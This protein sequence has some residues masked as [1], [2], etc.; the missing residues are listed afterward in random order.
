MFVVEA[1]DL[2]QIGG[3]DRETHD[4]VLVELRWVDVRR[5]LREAVW[6][7]PDVEAFDISRDVFVRPLAEQLDVRAALQRR[8]VGLHRTDE[9][10]RRFGQPRCDAGKKILIDPLM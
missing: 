6:D 4:Q 9:R 5:V 1:P 8:Y 7:D 10:E 3:D 2:R